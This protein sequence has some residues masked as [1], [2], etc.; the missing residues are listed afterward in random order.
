MFYLRAVVR[1]R[2]YTHLF[3]FIALAQYKT[4]FTALHKDYFGQTLKLRV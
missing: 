3:V 2:L 1:I 4:Y